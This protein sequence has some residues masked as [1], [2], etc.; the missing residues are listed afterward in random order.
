MKVAPSV[1]W[2]IVTVDVLG[3]C[4]RSNSNL[5]S[6]PFDWVT[7]Q[8]GIAVN[9][10]VTFATPLYHF[11]PSFKLWR[12][13]CPIRID[14]DLR[15]FLL[16]LLWPCWGLLLL[17]YFPSLVLFPQWCWL[18]LQL[19]FLLLLP[20]ALLYLRLFCCHFLQWT[21]RQWLNVNW[22]WR[23][24]KK[25]SISAMVLFSFTKPLIRGKTS[26]RGCPFST[27]NIVSVCHSWSF[28]QEI[29]FSLYCSCWSLRS[30]FL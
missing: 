11:T 14:S 13:L 16:W 22:A 5:V 18:Q 20:F 29:T 25:D 4:L 8:F 10:G 17:P 30:S 12:A 15:N 28:G 3:A 19:L 2:P 26:M 23:T 7:G 1:S 27:S 24:A 6:L 21:P 9:F